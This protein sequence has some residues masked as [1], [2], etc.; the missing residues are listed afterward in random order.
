MSDEIVEITQTFTYLGSEIHSSTS[1]ELEVN[2][3]QGLFSQ[4][5]NFLENDDFSVKYMTPGMSVDRSHDW[6]S[7]FTNSTS[8][9]A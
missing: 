7:A 9:T 8:G 1:C 4:K 6:P 2:R 3:R 5:L